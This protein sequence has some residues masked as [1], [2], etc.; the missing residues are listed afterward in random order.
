MT[1]TFGKAAPITTYIPVLS[2]DYYSPGPL[3]QQ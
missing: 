3:G 1:I 2:D